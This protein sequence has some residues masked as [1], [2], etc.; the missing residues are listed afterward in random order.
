[1]GQIFHPIP[2]YKN[3]SALHFSVNC[4]H[5]FLHRN[6][7]IFFFSFKVGLPDRLSNDELLQSEKMIGDRFGLIELP[8]YQGLQSP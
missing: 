5:D 2:S 1:M 3:L 4:I 7:R 8:T 6:T